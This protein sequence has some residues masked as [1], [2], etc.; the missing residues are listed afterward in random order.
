MRLRKHI[1]TVTHEFTLL[2]IVSRSFRTDTLDKQLYRGPVNFSQGPPSIFYAMEF[3]KYEPLNLQQIA[4]KGSE[5]PELQCFH[6]F[7]NSL[8]LRLRLRRWFNG[9]DSK[10]AIRNCFFMS[11]AISTKTTSAITAFFL[12]EN[13]LVLALSI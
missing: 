11:F 3:E 9:L 12:K 8:G 1:H 10:L 4:L 2:I 7:G 6:K 13:I 5:T